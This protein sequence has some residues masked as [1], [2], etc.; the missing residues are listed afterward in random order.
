[1]FAEMMSY[2]RVDISCAGLGSRIGL[3]KKEESVKR[4]SAN[5]KTSKY[6]ELIKPVIYYSYSTTVLS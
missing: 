3:S 1:M 5:I 4:E 2:V 6:N